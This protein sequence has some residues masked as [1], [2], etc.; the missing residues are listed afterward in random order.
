[1]VTST[2][3][4]HLTTRRTR[5]QRFASE[6]A[7]VAMRAGLY[8]FDRLYFST[9]H[10]DHCST[11]TNPSAKAINANTIAKVKD[12]FARAFAPTFATAVA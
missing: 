11:V 12:A 5:P 8:S 10:V 9:V 4:V 1:M 3:N 7:H 6:F 2:K